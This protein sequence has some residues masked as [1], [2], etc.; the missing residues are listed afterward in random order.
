MIKVELKDSLARSVGMISY[1]LGEKR[2]IVY[3]INKKEFQMDWGCNCKK[4]KKISE[5]ILKIY[6]GAC[7]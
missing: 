3:T 2:L 6:M 5:N 4:K 7:L 1:L